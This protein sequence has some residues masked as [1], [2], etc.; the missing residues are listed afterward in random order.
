MAD[1]LAGF[2]IGVTADRR[3]DEL[4]A[5]LQR[6]GARVVIAPALRIVPLTDDTDLREATREC[7]ARPPDVLMAN[8]GIGMRGW[9]EAAEGWGLA[10]PLRGVLSQAYV[11][12]RG[13][14]ARGA[15]RAAG[16]HDQWSPDSESCEE[17]VEHLVRRGV[18]GQVIAMQLHGDRQPECTSALED[19]GAT[20][21]EVPVYRW[22]P[23]TDPAP[24]HRLIDLVAGRLVDAVTF[25]SA[26]AAEALLRAAGDRTE[27][28][29][30]ALR[31]DVLASC[32]GAVTAEPLVRRGVP[33][34]APSRARLGA[35]V[36][37]IVDELPRRTVSI[38]AAGHLLTLRGHA[39]VVDGELRPLA[40]APMAVLRALATS[41]GRVLSR[42]ALLRTLPRGADE[43]AVEMAVA[44]LRA[45]LKA[46]RVVQTVVKRGYRLRID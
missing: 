27:T 30:E 31:G 25:T 24:L 1:E 29:L 22:A 42:T 7:L 37:T 23:P 41:P 9:L 40:P 33:V 20:V 6:R 43:H 3:R 34:S 39:A 12:A 4:A 16:L 13:P 19:A 38:K 21:I 2:T 17:V 44:R 28:V 8:T 18:A 26:P 15:I 36:R 32:V 35:L 5:L 14:K 45:G 10:E 46:P 11:V